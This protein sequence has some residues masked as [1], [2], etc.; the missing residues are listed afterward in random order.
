[1]RPIAV[2]QSSKRSPR[3][4]RA[5]WVS[6]GYDLQGLWW[7]DPASRSKWEYDLDERTMGRVRAAQG[8]QIIA[9][10]KPR[11]ALTNPVNEGARRASRGNSAGKSTDVPS[12]R[13]PARGTSAAQR[14]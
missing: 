8:A 7:T 9:A 1:M 13:A 5:E 11:E 4:I 2:P 14:K 6:I 10:L 12:A 3:G